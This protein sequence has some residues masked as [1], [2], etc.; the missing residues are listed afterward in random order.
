MHQVA[1]WLLSPHMQGYT[2]QTTGEQRYNGINA[3]LAN[4]VG[5]MLQTH[6]QVMLVYAHAPVD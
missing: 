6:E 1:S 2:N 3:T 4:Q 5:A